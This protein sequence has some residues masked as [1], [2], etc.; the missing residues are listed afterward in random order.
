MK[1]VLTFLILFRLSHA[2]ESNV[3][4]D[5]PVEALYFA[6]RSCILDNDS[7]ACD[8][9]GALATAF[10]AVAGVA[11]GAA[12]Q[13]YNRWKVSQNDEHGV[14]KLSERFSK[15]YAVQ[16]KAIE[17]GKAKEAMAKLD[18]EMF[19]KTFDNDNDRKKLNDWVRE[20]LISSSVISLVTS[21]Q[22]LNLRS[23]VLLHSK[24]EMKIL[25]PQLKTR[26]IPC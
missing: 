16:Q 19:G 15:I 3:T 2:A 24:L 20:F 14:R 9:M 13:L 11:G 21:E 1:I 17:I 5:G 10:P 4:C 26:K 8:R 18:Q 7:G 25:R 12:A 23:G 6:K 22:M